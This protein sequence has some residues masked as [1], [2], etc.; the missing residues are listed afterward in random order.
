MIYILKQ[1]ARRMLG[2]RKIQSVIIQEAEFA[3]GDKVID[4]G[5]GDG[6]LLARIALEYGNDLEYMGIE[7]QESVRLRA[8]QLHGDKGIKFKRA[9]ADHLPSV[10]DYYTQV[11]CMVS[12]HHFPRESWKACL[13]E[14]ARVLRPGGKLIIVEFGTPRTFAGR[15]L[16]LINTCRGLARGIE[17]VLKTEGQGM[18]LG[19]VEEKQQF[20][21]ITHLIFTK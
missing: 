20:G 6:A 3:P 18:G 9:F 4:I 16:S 15:L 11:I 2:L 8:E 1:W 10:Q 14:C 7:P 21:Y 13:T 17:D 19:L 5:C 12:F